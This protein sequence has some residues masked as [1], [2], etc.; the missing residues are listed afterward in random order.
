MKSFKKVILAW[1]ATAGILTGSGCWWPKPKPTDILK[2]E[3]ETKAGKI[4]NTDI[5]VPHWIYEVNDPIN[6][7][8]VTNFNDF[9]QN[10][11]FELEHDKIVSVS[12]YIPRIGEIWEP[13]E[14]TID[15]TGDYV[16][17]GFV[18]NSVTGRVVKVLPPEEEEKEKK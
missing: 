18:S 6:L 17:K 8:Q 14:T 3:I 15:D 9:N 11:E 7:I 2:V 5:E 13:T 10:G 4:I 1:L 16:E 12:G